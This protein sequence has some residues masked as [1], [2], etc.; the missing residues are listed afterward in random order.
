MAKV[1]ISFPQ[2]PLTL[3]LQGRG[4]EEGRRPL[5]RPDQRWRR[6]TQV[7]SQRGPVAEFGESRGQEGRPGRATR[8]ASEEPTP[9]PRS[10][11]AGR[12]VG[13]QRLLFR[14]RLRRRDARLRRAPSGP[15]LARP[16]PR[17]ANRRGPRPAGRWSGRRTRGNHPCH[18]R[19]RGRRKSPALP[20]CR[21]GRGC[22]W[23]RG[24]PRRRACGPVQSGRR[25]VGDRGPPASA[26]RVDAADA[27][28]GEDADSSLMGQRH[29]GGD[30]RGRRRHL[31]HGG[32]QV[33]AAGLAHV[34]RLGQLLPVRRRSGRP[35]AGPSTRRWSPARPRRRRTA[36]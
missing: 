14:E 15:P 33:T 7:G 27:A 34:F 31:R 26:A 6:L 9:P 5:A 11:C 29:R 35:S 16:P 21:P 4:R 17:R 32:G 1:R 25:N 12:R 22:S 30:G 36:A 19:R 18:S 10:R 13:V 2:H 8:P 24:R 28:G 3:S 20:A 23:P